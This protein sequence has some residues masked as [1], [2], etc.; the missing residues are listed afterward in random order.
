MD[1]SRENLVIQE[2]E[3]AITPVKRTSP[4]RA[5]LV[6]IAG[7]ASFFLLIPYIFIRQAISNAKKNPEDAALFEQMKSAW[8]FSK[9][10]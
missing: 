1:E 9:K 4:K 8:S 7:I 6:L 3:T 10:T 2:V 5:M